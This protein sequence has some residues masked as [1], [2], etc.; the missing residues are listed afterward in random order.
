MQERCHRLCRSLARPQLCGWRLRPSNESETRIRRSVEFFRESLTTHERLFC[1][2]LLLDDHQ[3]N[4]LRGILD[5][6][7]SW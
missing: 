5:H 6:V 1:R 2:S 7:D 4:V 3:G